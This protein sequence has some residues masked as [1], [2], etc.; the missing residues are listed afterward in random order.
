MITVICIVLHVLI[1]QAWD[2]RA[3]DRALPHATERTAPS[4]SETGTGISKIDDNT[5]IIRIHLPETRTMV[6][7]LIGVLLSVTT[8]IALRRRRR[9]HAYRTDT[10]E[11]GKTGE[12]AA[13]GTAAGNPHALPENAGGGEASTTGRDD[14]D[15]TPIPDTD[16]DG[17]D[18]PMLAQPSSGD[19]HM[20]QRLNEFIAQHISEVE[21]SVNDLAAAVY[22]SRSNLFRRL[23]TLYGITPNEYLRRKRL[24][25]ASALLRQNKYTVSDVCFMVGFSSPSYFS[26]CFKK[27][28]GIL[29]KNYIRN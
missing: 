8:A 14:T 10:G 24:L 19:I 6:L 11:S 1:L 5:I 17:I 7:M 4:S 9:N 23:K 25:S 26:S 2:S 20:L 13:Y 21:L 12:Q 15:T 27:H 18:L 28:F 29:P 3:D 16:T 22:M